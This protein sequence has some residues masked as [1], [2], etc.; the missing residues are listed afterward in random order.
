MTGLRW[1]G[2]WVPPAVIEQWLPP[3]FPKPRQRGFS[4]RRSA[5]IDNGSG[6]CQVPGVDI[7]AERVV[8]RVAEHEVLQELVLE[9]ETPGR[10]CWICPRLRSSWRIGWHEACD[11]QTPTLVSYD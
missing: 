3:A 5:A 11:P 9:R 1:A 6:F 10:E 2:R 4:S 7:K 8:V